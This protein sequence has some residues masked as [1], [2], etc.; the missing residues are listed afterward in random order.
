MFLFCSKVKRCAPAAGQL[1]GSWLIR[2]MRNEKPRRS[3]AGAIPIRRSTAE[4]QYLE[5]TGPPNL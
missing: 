4:N 1:S 3:R 2:V 5:S